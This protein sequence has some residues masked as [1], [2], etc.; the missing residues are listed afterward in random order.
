[1]SG[2]DDLS[3]HSVP[4][5]RPLPIGHKMILGV[6]GLL[7]LRVA[8]TGTA[9]LVVL[10]VDHAAQAD[11]SNVPYGNAVDA[12]A[13]AAKGI[14]NDDRGFLLSGDATFVTE[15]S[16]RTASARTAFGQAAA[17]GHTDA[18][19]AIIRVAQAQFESWV[20][21]VQHEFSQ[22]RAGDRA[23]AVA[24]S[25]VV[26]RAFRRIYEGTLAQAQNSGRSAEASSSTSLAQQSHRSIIIL[27]ISLGV[28]LAIGI[29]IAYWLVRVV[30][31]PVFRLVSLL[32]G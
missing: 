11:H 23:A 7:I 20:A 6:G 9:I 17:A 15:A 13:L 5:R 21:T 29:P 4:R 16:A 24:E 27:F 30:A 3:S 32:S 2:L 19:R 14:A 22:Y 25:V 1:M 28:A 18:E 12:A 31:L 26:N 10:G 8:A